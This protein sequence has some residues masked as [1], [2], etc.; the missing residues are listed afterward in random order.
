VAAPRN[1]LAR[2]TCARAQRS[3]QAA[4]E[5]VNSKPVSCT[6]RRRFQRRCDAWGFSLAA[7]GSMQAAAAARRVRSGETVDGAVTEGT[8]TQHGTDGTNAKCG[9]TAETAAANSVR[10][11]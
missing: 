10:R 9:L 5:K 3:P 2:G 4:D 8:R 6:A 7:A 11:T 1:C